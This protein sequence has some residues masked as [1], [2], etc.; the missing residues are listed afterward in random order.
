MSARKR[1]TI[2]QT[3]RNLYL[4][5]RF[6]GD[7]EAAQRGTLVKRVVRRKTRRAIFRAFR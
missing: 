4:T 6:L 2:E 1:S 3:R 7:V 5:Q